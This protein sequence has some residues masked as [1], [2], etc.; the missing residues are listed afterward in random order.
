[1]F[2]AVILLMFLA[3]P[4]QYINPTTLVQ[5]PRYTQVISLPDNG[6]VFISGQAPQR[7][8]GTVV[9]G[10]FV[11]Q[12]DQALENLRLALTAAGLTPADIIKI[13][14]FVVDLPAHIEAYR[15]ARSKFFG[16]LTHLPTSTT[17]GVS[18]IAA[19]GALIEIDAVAYKAIKK[20]R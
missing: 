10:D 5:N 2:Q 7:P 9:S 18:S 6:L 16:G 3:T 11:A 13:D 4:P 19:P 17:I 12:A 14:T 20:K 8:D 15:V 1:M